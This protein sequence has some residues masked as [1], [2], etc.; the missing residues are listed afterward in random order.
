[1]RKEPSQ[2]LYASA[3]PERLDRNCTLPAKFMRLLDRFELHEIS[4]R[5]EGDFA[6]KFD[7][8]YGRIAVMPPVTVVS[9]TEAK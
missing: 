7:A 3:S 1:M 2:V 4:P 9:H 8:F 5:Y 6:A